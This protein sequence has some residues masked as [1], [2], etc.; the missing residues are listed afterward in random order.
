MM[1][2][3]KLTRGWHGWHGGAHLVVE[4]EPFRGPLVANISLSGCTFSEE[5]LK[6]MPDALRRNRNILRVE[7]VS[8]MMQE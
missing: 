4:G 8:R 6:A 7:D 3:I 2:G 5:V 1:D